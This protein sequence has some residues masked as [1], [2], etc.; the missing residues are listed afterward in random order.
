[1]T[2][3]RGRGLRVDPWC[4]HSVGCVTSLPTYIPG[5]HFL[6]VRESG[7]GVSVAGEERA[8]YCRQH[9][10][11]L[12]DCRHRKKAEIA[13]DTGRRKRWLC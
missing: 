6:A 7:E 12:G 1:M 10:H 13:A 5:R 11:P 8:R 4:M 9:P 2:M 3:G